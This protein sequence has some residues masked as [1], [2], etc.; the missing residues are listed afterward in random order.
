M[1]KQFKTR[2]TDGRGNI[3]KVNEVTQTPVG[4]TVYYE[5]TDTKLQYYCLLEAFIDRF[6]EL[7]ND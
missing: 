2:F 6:K 4:L 1:I 5:N 7:V 3:F